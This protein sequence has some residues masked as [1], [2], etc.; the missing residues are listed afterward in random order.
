[1]RSTSSLAE[2][3]RGRCWLHPRPAEGS[4]VAA[5]TANGSGRGCGRWARAG[6]T[7]SDTCPGPQA[8]LGRTGHSRCAARAGARRRRAARCDAARVRGSRRPPRQATPPT[9]VACRF[10]VGQRSPR[11]RAHGDRTSRLGQ[12]LLRAIVYF[13]LGLMGLSASYAAIRIYMALEPPLPKDLDNQED[14]DLLLFHKR[15]HS[16]FVSPALA[17][18][19]R[20]RTGCRIRDVG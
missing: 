13:L 19:R 5:V 18:R 17:P 11:W 3:R 8:E 15:R 14:W 9:V 16:R 20:D 4:S 1:M 6:T 2:P 7:S 10:P 12:A